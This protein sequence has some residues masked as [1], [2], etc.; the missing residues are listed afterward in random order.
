MQAQQLDRFDLLQSALVD[1]SSDIGGQTG[2][3]KVAASTAEDETAWLQEF[4]AQSVSG[5][6]NDLVLQ[7]GSAIGSIMGWLLYRGKT[8]EGIPSMC[9]AL[10]SFYLAV[11][12]HRY[13]QADMERVHECGQ[14]VF[15]GESGRR[16]RA[17]ARRCQG[18][19]A[20][21]GQ[22]AVLPWR[23]LVQDRADCPCKS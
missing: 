18:S 13:G 21:A 3:A 7:S 10:T 17:V 11:A 12:F 16:D 8:G 20:H 2:L 15:R 23:Q 1:F 5:G 19:V 4:V 6:D 9:A 14:K 22:V